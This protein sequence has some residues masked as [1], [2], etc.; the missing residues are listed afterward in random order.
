[1]WE[2]RICSQGASV[3]PQGGVTKVTNS[4][5]FLQEPLGYCTENLKECSFTK[6]DSTRQQVRTEDAHRGGFSGFAHAA[7]PF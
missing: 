6:A 2:A 3:Q 1:M 4:Q 7:D 5:V